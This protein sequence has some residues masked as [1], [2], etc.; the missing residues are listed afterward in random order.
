MIKNKSTLSTGGMIIRPIHLP[1]YRFSGT[2]LSPELHKRYFAQQFRPLLHMF[3][4]PKLNFQN[5]PGR[6]KWQISK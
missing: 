1:F 2:P 3:K 5:K 6:V 4:S